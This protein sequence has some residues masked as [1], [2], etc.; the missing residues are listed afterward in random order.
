MFKEYVQPWEG[1]GIFISMIVVIFVSIVFSFIYKTV[2]N[3]TK[4]YCM[5][6]DL[7]CR[8]IV[9]RQRQHYNTMVGL[10]IVGLSTLSFVFA[11]QTRLPALL[12]L[13]YPNASVQLLFSLISLIS[14]QSFSIIGIIEYSIYLKSFGS[15]VKVLSYFIFILVSVLF[16]GITIKNLPPESGIIA[17]FF[18]PEKNQVLKPFRL[19]SET[20]DEEETIM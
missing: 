20:D 7:L 11:L 17:K 15:S 6:E 9:E 16:F 19:S 5:L 18:S 8:F 2:E 12:H 14:L 1:V 4:D 10:F 13:S 3:E